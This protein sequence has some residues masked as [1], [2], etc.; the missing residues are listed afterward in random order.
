MASFKTGDNINHNLRILK[1]LYDFYE[2]GNDVQRNLLCKP[3][4]LLLVSILEA[5]LHDFHVRIK[6]YTMEGVKNLAISVVNHIRNR[7]IDELDKYIASAKKHNFFDTPNENLYEKMDDL[8]KLRNR[9]HIQNTK[10]HF[11]PDEDAAFN[12]KRKILAEK[13][14]EKTLKTMDT[15]YSRSSDFAGH[16]GDF[17]LPWDEYFS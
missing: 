5:I 4:I 12:E 16:V 14:L 3:I 15:K 11:E 9:I 1:L 10:H 2:N 7:K 17:Q 8:R 6:T 13:V